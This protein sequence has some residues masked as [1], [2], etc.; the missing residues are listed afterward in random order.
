MNATSQPHINILP[1]QQGINIFHVLSVEEYKAL[2]DAV[3]KL[4]NA[5]IQIQIQYEGAPEIMEHEAVG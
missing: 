2:N 1:T 4:F 3:W 5:G